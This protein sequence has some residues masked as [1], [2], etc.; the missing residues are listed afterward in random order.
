M[1]YFLEFLINALPSAFCARYKGSYRFKIHMFW[2]THV[3]DSAYP[4]AGFST[5]SPH[6]NVLVLNSLRY[7]CV[8]VSMQVQ[9]LL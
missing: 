5:V 4:C 1:L 7:L 2:P 9:S 6:L 3:L 8:Q